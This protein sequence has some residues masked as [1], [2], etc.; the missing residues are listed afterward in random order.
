M[1]V[2]SNG[3]PF[4][5]VFVPDPDPDFDWRNV[6]VFSAGERLFASM[7]GFNG[8]AATFSSTDGTSWQHAVGSFCR[9]AMFEEES[10]A[11][12]C[13]FGAVGLSTDGVAF[14]TVTVPGNQ[15]LFGVAA[16]AGRFVVVGSFGTT[17]A[18]ATG[19]VW[20]AAADPPIA[21]YVPPGTS[22]QNVVTDIV[23]FNA[24]FVAASGLGVLTAQPE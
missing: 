14:N 18:S 11:L 21:E 22:V 7:L 23:F 3:E 5:D 8:A 16:G 17:M 24:R 4:T 19:D 12:A 9:D 15:T 2:S 6:V 13:N 10:Y 1:L 20:T